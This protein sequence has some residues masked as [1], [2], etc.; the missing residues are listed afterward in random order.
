MP[1][2]LY[3]SVPFCKAKC[4]FCNFASGVGNDA[5]VE[6]YVT[7]LV[8][9]ID[10]ARRDADR[11]GASLPHL[12]DT[13]YFGGGTPSLLQP[14]QLRAIFAALRRNFEL[15][16]HAEITL[17]AAPGQID[18][19][20]LGAAL[21]EG[22]NRISLG[23]QSFVDAEAQ[24]VGRSHTGDE[25]LQEFHRLHRAGVANVGADLIA[26]L[27]LQT[28]ESWMQT[29]RMVGEAELEH[30]SVYL[31]E[32]DE[33]SRLGAEVLRGGERFHATRV[34]S[35]DLASAMYERACKELPLLGFSQYEISNFAREGF[36]SAHNRK[37]WTRAPYF[38]FGLDAHSML[39]RAEG[40]G[41][42]RF[43]NA[44]ELAS[45]GMKTRTL[46]QTV[47]QDE[48]FEEAVF[49]G[50]RML[51]GIEIAAL[52]ERFGA[53]RVKALRQNVR[54]LVGTELMWEDAG[55]WGLTLRG[56]LVSNDVFGRILEPVAA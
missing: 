4:S 29:L 17:E 54:E 6:R 39:L 21:E 27:P 19:A 11:I 14:E 20:L 38:G 15:L 46:P 31:F 16:P 22:I 50:L 42:L 5:A 32:I 33:D 10:A 47:E 37:Y 34:A 18:D 35:E 52:E 8:E 1:L 41:A 12:V 49:L 3:L 45:Y 56:R 48:A 25:C 13:V 24:A 23:V 9:E 44:E 55:R 30:L 7:Q 51:E 28:M 43:A 53:V 36:R 26:G 40:D 2:G